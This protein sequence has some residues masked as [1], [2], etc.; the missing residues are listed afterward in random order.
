MSSDEHPERSAVEGRPAVTL[1]EAKGLLPGVPHGGDTSQARNDPGRLLQLR[2]QALRS[3]CSRLLWVS[4][5][6]FSLRS[7]ALGVQNRLFFTAPARSFTESCPVGNG[8][9][10][11]MLFGG[12][13]RERVVLNDKE[14]WTGRKHDWDNPEALK[15]LPE[16]RRLL[17]AGRNAEAQ[18]LLERSFVCKDGG[19]SNPIW[20]TYQTLGDLELDFGGDAP[21]TGYSRTL[22]M[23]T[24][25]ATVLYY[26]NGARFRRELFASYPDRAI[27]MRLTTDTP[28]ALS[29]SARLRRR[30]RAKYHA[31][32]DRTYVMEGRMDDGS[33]GDGMAYVACL[34]AAPE[35]GAWTGDDGGFHFHGAKAVTLVVTSQTDYRGPGYR[36]AAIRRCLDLVDT[37]YEALRKK[38]VDDHSRLFNRVALDLGISP[39]SGLPTPERLGRFYKGEADPNLASTYFQYGRYLLIASSRPGTLPANLQ[40]VWAEEYKVPWNG[41]YH[42]NINVQMNY[43]PAES[44]NL[45]ECHLPLTDYIATLVKPGSRTARNWY[46]SPGWVA[47][48]INNVWGFTDPGEGAGWGSTSTGGA[49]LCW[50]LWNHY[51]Y[52]LDR[53]YL[54]RVYPLMRESARFHLVN[55]VTEPKH[56][57]LVTAPSNSPENAYRTAAGEELFTCMGP[58]IDQQ[59]LRD[60]FANTVAAAR[61]LGVDAAFAKRLEDA[62]SRLAPNRIGRHGQLQEWMEDYDEPEP[63]HRH[64]S[65]LWGLH[66]G[67]EISPDTTPEL[68]RA[69]RVTLE[70]RG[71]E[72][73][74]WSMAWKIN[75]WA[76]L[77]DGDRAY[78]LLR[79]LLRPAVAVG[80]GYAGH[81][82]GTYWNLFDAHPPFQIDGNFGAAAGIAEMLMQSHT[83]IIRLLPALPKAW[84]GGSVR[85]LVARGGTVVDI[86]WKD[87][88]PTRV[89][90]EARNTGT[91]RVAVPEGLRIVAPP[92]G[93]AV[94]DGVAALSLRKGQRL[95][96][97]FG[98]A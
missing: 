82:S 73:T 1:N 66:P 58:T 21:A 30:E 5:M 92:R 56:G 51:E 49:W 80:A 78:K 68:A 64:V 45:S 67:R 97:T 12:V 69:A 15:A 94:R 55:L 79:D 63:H 20:G 35:G 33:G 91:C 54:K 90:L 57:W 70:R 23:A 86:T 9:Q 27:I 31:G 87:G 14:L 2:A 3:G 60:L 65:H 41:D 48:V 32:L 8:Y 53:A 28:G 11:A 76:R 46:G 85:G 72:A 26:R 95:A 37:P 47:H 4:L 77:G 6:A 34:S 71:D 17:L 10:G 24:G 88:R 19:S 22:D 74:G 96:L 42:L 36:D 59:I 16:I 44:T 75:F 52:T 62:R 40:G 25:I 93:V 18:S 98:T 13:A 84:P 89:T 38:A 39:N 83:G 7:S 43:W 61:L 29:F 81:G 50:H